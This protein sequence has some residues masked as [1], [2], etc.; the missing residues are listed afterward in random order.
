MPWFGLASPKSNGFSYY[1]RK[2]SKK[3]NF[4]ML[5]KMGRQSYEITNPI[6]RIPP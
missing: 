6:E 1:L 4:L 2:Q 5:V 3:L